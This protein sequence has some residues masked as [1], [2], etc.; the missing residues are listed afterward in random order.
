LNLLGHF[1]AV[2]EYGGGSRRGCGYSRRKR[3]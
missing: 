2:V 3:G 1:V